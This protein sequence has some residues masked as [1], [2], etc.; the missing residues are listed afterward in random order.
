[1]RSLKMRLKRFIASAILGLS[2]LT[3]SAGVTGVTPVTVG[4]AVRKPV[5]ELKAKAFTV[6]LGSQMDV[7][8][9]V[10]KSVKRGS[11]PI[12]SVRVA[13]VRAANGKKIGIK[14]SPILTTGKVPPKVLVFP[15]RAGAYKI[16]VVATDDK[17]NKTTSTVNFKVRPKKLSSYVKGMKT[18]TVTKGS[19]VRYLKGITYDK[20]KIRTIRVNSSFVDTDKRGTYK[21]YYNIIGIAGDK[22]RITRKVNVIAGPS[23]PA[24][25]NPT[26]TTPA[27]TGT[28]A[29]H[30]KGITDR[31][32]LRASKNLDLMSGVT[33]DSTIQSVQCLYSDESANPRSY[34]LPGFEYVSQRIYDSEIIDYL[35]TTKAGKK[36]RVECNLYV[37]D[38]P[39]A[40]DLAQ[41]IP[42]YTDNNTFVE[43][44]LNTKRTCTLQV[45]ATKII[46]PRHP[47]YVCYTC[48]GELDARDDNWIEEHQ[49]SN[50]HGS[51][52]LPKVE[53]FTITR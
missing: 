17:G 30:V 1:M 53:S 8:K 10:I 6:G 36:Q 33:W 14:N 40:E 51:G 43:A 48:N 9:N 39:T 22:L 37:V 45:S 34:N 5:I 19:S 50:M 52:W 12:R 7:Y 25:S 24:P 20:S 32:A 41:Y 46:V 15:S 18:L 16:K 2:V 11:Y 21:V 3:I 38:L 27:D 28:P 29:S 31:V 26:P 4:A 13:S 35:I 23:T 42:V 49:L 44:N 47:L